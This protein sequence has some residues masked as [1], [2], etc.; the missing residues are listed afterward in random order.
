MTDAATR[1]VA[2]AGADRRQHDRIAGPLDGVR[3]GALETPVRMFDL[4]R[5]GCFINALH[6]QAPGVRFMVRID[7]P[8]VGETTLTVETL[9]QRNG[10][11]FAVRF[12][13]VDEETASRLN[14]V[15]EQLQEPV[16]S[17][18]PT[19][20]DQDR[21]LPVSDGIV[22]P[23]GSS[24]WDSCP[25][26]WF[27]DARPGG[28]STKDRAAYRARSQRL[29]MLGSGYRAVVDGQTVALVNLSLSGAQVCGPVRVSRNHP[30]ILRI[31]RPHDDLSCDAI[32][33]VRWLEVESDRSTT[34]SAYRMGLAFERWDVR[35][36]KE[37]MQH[38]ARTFLPGSE[39]IDRW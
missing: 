18:P 27:H 35:Q 3:L 36:L 2:D 6:E 23:F 13:D 22:V 10:F 11:G 5:G 34:E 21:V 16:R 19:A 25:D 33:R 30:T 9:Y 28:P 8:H 17:N 39:I 37:I 31:G 15:V 20:A 24:L 38:C 4:S 12:V 7:L 14:Q 26:T 29:P 1:S 32:V